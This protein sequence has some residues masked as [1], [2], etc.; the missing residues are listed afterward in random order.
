MGKGRAIYPR[1]HSGPSA[2]KRKRKVPYLGFRRQD[3]EDRRQ[4]TEDRRQNSE[5]MIEPS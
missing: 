2:E 3:T 5:E 4:N 1:K